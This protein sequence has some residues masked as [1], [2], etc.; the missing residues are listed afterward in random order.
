LLS[1]T[2]RDYVTTLNILILNAAG[3][4]LWY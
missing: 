4:Y 3:N 1:H 2:L